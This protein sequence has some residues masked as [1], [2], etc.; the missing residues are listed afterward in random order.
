MR[1]NAAIR[2]SSHRPHTLLVLLNPFGGTRKARETWR[3][4][5]MPV[6]TLAGTLTHLP[7]LHCLRP[8]PSHLV[9]LWHMALM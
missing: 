9:P 2:Q 7:C 8:S 5:A 4:V 3:D 6:F 1:I